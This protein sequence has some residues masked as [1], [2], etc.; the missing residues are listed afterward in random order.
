MKRHLRKK[1]QH[2]REQLDHFSKVREQHRQGRKKK[3]MNTI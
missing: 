1:E 3:G 2:I